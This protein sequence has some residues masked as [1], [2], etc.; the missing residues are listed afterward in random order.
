M[1]SNSDEHS[2]SS[3]GQTSQVTPVK[4][5]PLEKM[6][7]IE[8]GPIVPKCDAHPVND[9]KFWCNACVLAICL[10]C[11]DE[12]HQTHKFELLKSVLKQKVEKSLER[13]NV[14]KNGMNKVDDNIDQCNKQEIF[15]NRCIGKSRKF[16]AGCESLKSIPP[17]Y[18]EHLKSLQAFAEGDESAEVDRKILGSFLKLLH[19]TDRDFFD[20]KHLSFI[21]VYSDP[22][23][24]WFVSNSI[25]KKGVD[26]VNFSFSLTAE[27]EHCTFLIE[28]IRC[29]LRPP[30]TIDFRFTA[31]FPLD[32]AEIIYPKQI[33]RYFCDLVFVSLSSTHS[34]RLPRSLFEGKKFSRKPKF[35]NLICEVLVH[36]N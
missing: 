22:K 20:M 21:E 24:E 14:L 9:C 4:E 26:N 18:E 3:S 17:I 16:K 1:T 33:N 11:V 5:E 32:T 6:A 29:L 15:S 28:M 30:I 31:I 23:I 12:D 7:R 2:C 19:K 34:L 8:K 13:L 25:P 35:E 36:E 10:Q 27:D